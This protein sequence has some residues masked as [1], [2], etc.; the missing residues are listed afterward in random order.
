MKVLQLIHG[1]PPR[2]SA[3][4][5]VYTQLLTHAL[6]DRQHE[7]MVFSRQENA[8]LPEYA[9]TNERDP[10]DERVE[11]RLIN[12]FR[13][14]DRYRHEE[15]EQ[16][17]EKTLSEFKPDILHIG[18]LNHLSTSVVKK[19]ADKGIPIVFTLHDFWLMCPRGQ[20]LRTYSNPSEDLDPLCS[21][22]I[23]RECA[24]SC[25]ARHFSGNPQEIEADINYWEG[26]VHQRMNHIK[27]MAPL[28]DL[29][30]APS[31]Y[32]QDRFVNEFGLPAKKTIYLDYGFNLKR[33]QGRVRAK[34]KPFVFGYIGTHKQA[35]GIHHL[36]QAFAEIK[37]DPLLRIWGSPSQPFTSSLQA[38]IE[39]LAPDI[40]RRIEWKG[41]YANYRLIEDVF[42]H[43]DAIVVPSIWGENSPLVI[44]E[45][46]QCRIP[47]ITADFGGMG[48]YVKHEINGLVFEH[49]NP[50]AL[51]EQMQRF[52]DNPT[53]ASH[54]G[55]RGYFQS[56]TGNIP[57]IETHAQEIENLYEAL[58]TK[59]K[60]GP[61]RITFDT[62]PDD[63]NLRCIMC[64]EHSI[65]SKCQI[66][67]K[68]EGRPRR[69]MDIALMRKVLTESQGSPLKE[70]IPSTMGEPLLYRDFEEI[71]NLCREFNVKLNLTT[72][73]TFPGYGAT[74]WAQLIVPLA[75]DVKISWNG[76]TKA[77][78]EK[79]MIG[80]NFEKVLQNVR[81]F[82]KIRDDHAACG[83]N[84]CRMTFQLTFL[85]ENVHELADIIRLAASLGINRVKGHHL[86]IFTKEMETQ[87]MRRSPE[88]IQRWNQTVEEALEAA[89]KN[90]L[91]SGEKVLLENIFPLDEQ[92]TQDI[93]PEGVCPF[94]GKEAWVS[95]EGRFGPCCAPNEQRKTLGDFGNVQ[96]R[97]IAEI[98][99]S[100]EYADL[101]KNYLN[102]PVCKGCNMRKKENYALVGTATNSP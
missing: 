73:G 99:S 23:D 26:W 33:L 88:V 71:L 11:V 60:P 46:L 29:F 79:I 39:S 40:Q 63:C 90:R 20:F 86:W 31:R 36:L 27:E 7:V 52:S 38:Y 77:T 102:Y 98:F 17:F 72:N 74:K 83:G 82:I 4:S 35:K 49:R 94:L 41:G 44:H 22:Q 51:A 62:N 97:S 48:E 85:E 2:Y 37:G 1:Y 13:T 89:E 3:G 58:L 91:P 65:Y 69:R 30:I 10:L 59:K 101:Q 67:R 92:A 54:L 80:S 16:A 28:V 68:A 61:W 19:A 14:R 81:D 87:S 93:L 32:L 53:F 12:M 75:S 47:V 95:A 21:K 9:I 8:F 15:V 84:F 70:I 55:E 6:L 50:R 5:E 64:E 100:P 45:A 76:A 25:Y 57:D 56:T 24:T 78:Q 43:V 66:D 96:N 34:E 18:H 42:N